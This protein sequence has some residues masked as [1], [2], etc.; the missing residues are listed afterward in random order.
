MGV[1]YRARQISLKRIV[2]VKML[3][4]HPFAAP[5]Q[6]ERLHLEAETAGGLNHP[7]I[8]TIYEFG[9]HAGQ[10]YFAMEYVEGQSEEQFTLARSSNHVTALAYSADGK[11]LAVRRQPGTVTLWDAVAKRVVA[12]LPG[13]GW[14]KALAFSAREDL[15]AWGSQE[16]TGAPIVVVLAANVQKEIARLPHSTGVVAVAFASDATV[17]ATLSQDGEVKVWQL[18]SRQVVASLPTAGGSSDSTTSLRG[19]RAIGAGVA[20]KMSGG[21]NFPQTVGHWRWPIGAGR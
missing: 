19:R 5:E 2:A 3:P 10:F 9:E 20:S 4:V 1:V 15:L 11:W 13:A 7:N 8:V 16:D 18:A 6:E 21:R 17:L 14:P 12:E